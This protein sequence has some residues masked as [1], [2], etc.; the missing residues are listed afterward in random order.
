[1][2]VA[3]VL[4]SRST[5]FADGVREI[6]GAGVDV[7]VNSLAGEAMERSL[8]ALRPFGRFVE[9]GKRDYV[10]NTH[11][12]L[13]PFRRNLSYFGVDMD[14]LMADRPDLCEK[15]YAE[16]MAQFAAGTLSPLPH[17]VLSAGNVAEAFH[18]MQQ[19]SHIGKIVVHPPKLDTIRQ[20]LEP[21]S[22]R[23]DGTHLITGAFGGFGIEIAKW[24]V[25]NGARHLVMIG[26]RGP[27]SP[28]IT[29]VLNDFAAR[30]VAV[31]AEACD[32]TNRQALERLFARIKVTMP[33]L[34]GVIHAAMVLE[35]STL[36]NLDAERMERVLAPKVKG[37]DHLDTLTRR[38]KL[39]YFVLFSTLVTLIGN[40]GQGNY[41]AAN[42]FMEGLAR[43]R[44]QDGLPALAIGWGPI[45]D[46]GVL[47]RNNLL[48]S[49]VDKLSGVRGMTAC[50]GLELMAQALAQPADDIDLA[51]VTIAP[52]ESGFGGSH[53][54]VLRSPTYAALSH[55]GERS[56][57][58]DE[59]VDVL[60]LLDTVGLAG[61]R[62]DVANAIVTQLAHVLHA[63]PED[64]SRARPL[65]EIGLDSLMALELTV[66]LETT[67]GAYVSL[68]GTGGHATVL[69]IAD[70][71]IAQVGRASARD[72]SHATGLAERHMNEVDAATVDMI[73]DALATD[74]PQEKTSPLGIKRAT[75]G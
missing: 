65:G 22:P 31:L 3:H 45:T 60:E 67:F 18:L 4:D 64:V 6:T 23:V 48:E 52:S 34:A 54:A 11:I 50:E 10:N 38:M 63:R 75:S 12:G 17:S 70:E 72:D 21:F 30:G 42:A 16:V 46:V 59:R 40:A 39:D 24:L 73:K 37:A 32:V 56:Q 58:E 1:L 28:E 57:A 62:R 53:L 49:N 69:E 26:R 14:Q 9:L 29:A 44:R 68:V 20:P 5:A 25:D 55:G 36:A 47:V 35:D 43:R 8:G 27:T 66:N 71:I 33:P 51:V 15:L 2:G 61:A 74:T 19:S 41:V 13:R 7:V